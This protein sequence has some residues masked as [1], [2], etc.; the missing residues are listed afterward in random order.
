MKVCGG[1]GLKGVSIW[2]SGR[3]AGNLP[4][5]YYTGIEPQVDRYGETRSWREA[6]LFFYYLI[7]IRKKRN[8]QFY[9]KHIFSLVYYQT[10][11]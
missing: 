10:L 2:A 5:Y 11:D 8:N 7:N 3:W 1:G 4:G 6:T 9:L